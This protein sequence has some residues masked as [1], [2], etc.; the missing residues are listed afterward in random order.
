[1]RASTATELIKRLQTKKV[2]TRERSKLDERTIEIRLTAAGEAALTEH[3]SLDP[4][5]LSD[6]LNALTAQERETLIASVEKMT[7]ALA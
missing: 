5:K 3:T 1:M 4:R 2:L 6:G 7:R